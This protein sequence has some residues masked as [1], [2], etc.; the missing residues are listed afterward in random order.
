MICRYLLLL[1]PAAEV[2]ALA[3]GCTY[4]S[5]DPSPTGV[6]TEV[7]SKFITDDCFEVTSLDPEKV[8]TYCECLLTPAATPTPAGNDTSFTDTITSSK[9]SLASSTSAV[10]TESDPSL[11]S[12]GEAAPPQ[13][14]VTDT[15]SSS[16]PSQSSPAPESTAA[17]ASGT[18]T[19][20]GEASASSQDA[21]TRS[22]ETSSGQSSSGTSSSP[23]IQDGN[24]TTSGTTQ[25]ATVSQQ[26]SS[27]ITTSDSV[28]GTASVTVTDTTVTEEP[29]PVPTLSSSGAL[30]N[31]STLSTPTSS[32]GNI[33]S[34]ATPTASNHGTKQT[35]LVVSGDT[36]N[37][38]VSTNA[39]AAGPRPSTSSDGSVSVTQTLATLPGSISVVTGSP[40]HTN[41]RY[42]HVSS[43]VTLQSPTPST[44]AGWNSTSTGVGR[45]GPGNSGANA[46]TP[47]L[48]TTNRAQ[49]PGTLSTPVTRNDTV[50]PSGAPTDGP[51]SATFIS[52][53]GSITGS[54]T[55]LRISQ[56]TTFTTPVS[57]LPSSGGYNWNSTTPSA[58]S[59]APASTFTAAN[60]TSVTR[61]AAVARETCYRHAQDP[62]GDAPRRALM[63]NARLREQ[64]VSMPSLYIE[65][66]DFESEGV[67]PLWLTVRDSTEST[68]SL[69]ISNRSQI[70]V[71]DRDGTSM[72][73][74][75]NGIYFSTKD[76]RYD[77][78][79]TFNDFLGQLASLSGTECSTGAIKKRLSD[80]PFSQTLILQDQC[81]LPVGRGIR[82]FPTLSVGPSECT[83]V[84]VDL[85]T[86]T[87]DFDCTF[88]GSESG[89][90]QCQ[91]AIKHDVVDFL[92]TDPF[93]GACPDL[94]TVVTTLG[95]TGKDFLSRESLRTS[96]FNEGL[97]EEEEM[98]AD[99][100]L[101]S[102]E[103]MWR[104]LAEVFA[105][106][107]SG[108][109]ALEAYLQ[110]Y[111]RY[112]DLPT[113]VCED[114]HASEIPLNLTLRAGA[115]RFVINTLNFAP[116]R[117][118]PQNV[119]IQDPAKLAC[120][121]QGSV[122]SND[123]DGDDDDDDDTCGYPARAFV[124]GS[125]CVCGK[126][127]GGDSI[128][129][130]DTECDNFVGTC[131]T[132]RDC[133]SVGHVGF[134]CMT[135]TCC[136]GGVC[137][138]PYACSENGTQL[139][140]YDAIQM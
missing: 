18:N 12:S 107:E 73:L 22:I 27:V 91:A 110:L 82:S 68:H 140:T 52:I 1:A 54:A 98:D 78:S 101:D 72:K 125:G 30:T 3:S 48:S 103:R 56:L 65:S 71:V 132:D 117:T 77:V 60:F 118:T 61:T 131:E 105:K 53:T 66:V 136:G 64:N 129:F 119:T 76:C 84:A 43:S 104:V 67:Q 9:G 15:P 10:S 32:V 96:L 24:P 97:S 138:D 121:S 88:P 2:F 122:S 134:V 62:Q 46:T 33:S 36:G 115:S 39:T 83:D 44:W 81:G 25:G 41:S 108:Q 79:I 127:V 4:D 106:D 124:R 95:A 50:S 99:R 70:A 58:N 137:V 130:E 90:L 38:S 6:G 42:Y 37:I 92:T 59:T 139:V 51:F 113:D 45:P 20:S 69:D 94:S 40:D 74:D 123:G 26:N 21:A 49:E 34:A 86:G 100:A 133:S 109:S 128:A 31:S 57:P 93:G 16:R 14:P 120:C 7:C 116:E 11:S 112:R 23:S 28:N 85:R 19:E 35:T 75:R 17:E 135:G 87:W 13:T 5:A 114:I 89:T 55:T 63:R 111:N 47:T 80:L 29:S 126:T 102:Y 8:S